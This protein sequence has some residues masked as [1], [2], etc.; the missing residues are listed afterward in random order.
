[1]DVYHASGVR[2]YACP[3]IGYDIAYIWPFWHEQDVEFRMALSDVQLRQW[4][5]RMNE[6]AK[7]PE[8]NVNKDV[9]DDDDELKSIFNTL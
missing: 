5:H 4:D 8:L 6:A 7:Q 1:M 9:G 3:K 2:R